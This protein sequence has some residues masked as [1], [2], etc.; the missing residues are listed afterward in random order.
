MEILLELIYRRS[1][2][3][4]WM[5][6]P[7]VI[8]GIGA[9]LM[10]RRSRSI[11]RRNTGRIVG[12]MPGAKASSGG[13]FTEN[14]IELPAPPCPARVR[15]WAHPARDGR[16]AIKYTEYVGQ[17]GFA[18]R[19]LRIAT[20]GWEPESAVPKFATGDSQF[21]M[22]YSIVTNDPA[23][24]AKF[25]DDVT[26]DRIRRIDALHSGPFLL[27]LRGDQL[28]V[29]ANCGLAD[30]YNLDAFIDGNTALAAR[31]TG[32]EERG[33][34]VEAMKTAEKGDC[35]VCATALEERKQVKCRGC[36]T[37]HHAD[38]WAYNDGCAVF[39]CGQRKIA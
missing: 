31:A 13:L 35:P 18:P 33:V 28:V 6:I 3:P 12:R 5:W 21:D 30:D 1:P 15:F 36:Q 8:V 23:W 29:R 38:C 17:V 14:R 20:E 24:A 32:R 37:P 7:I 19:R 4:L 2:L 27:D 11:W 34:E 22:A 26:R 39:A 25:L 10:D 16:P 9:A